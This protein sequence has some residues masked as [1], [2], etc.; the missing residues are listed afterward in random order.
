MN[1]LSLLPFLA[2]QT[3]INF[4]NLGIY[5]KEIGDKFTVFGVDIAYYGIAIAVGMICG[6]LISEWT[7]K[8]TG[9]NP[10]VY[11]DFAIW[12]I[13]ISVICARLYYVIF[14]WEAFAGQPLSIFNLRTGGLAIY[15]GVIGGITTAFVYSRIHK[16]AWGQFFDT[17]VVGLLTGQIIGRWGNFFNREAFGTYTDSLFAMQVDVRNVSSYFNPNVSQKIVEN[18]Y[19]DKPEALANILEIRNNAMVIDGATYIQVHP[20]FLYESVWN[21]VLLIFLLIYTKH[22]KFHGEIFL[23]YLFVYG[24]GRL[25][26]E[27]LRTDQLF[28]WGT[29]LAVSQLLSGVLMV[30]SAV[31]YIFLWK[32]NKKAKATVA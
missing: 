16:I 5:L 27:G 26:I 28:L 2:E 10:D 29:P 31:G 20:T 9:Q 23:L 3:D 32:K 4:P 12:A 8:R 1:I 19:A 21:L 17:A 13:I 30:L 18:A 7:A 22:K 25:W 24:A 14:N 15:G 11:L 6:Y